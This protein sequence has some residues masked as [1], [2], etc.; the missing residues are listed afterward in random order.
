MSENS[1]IN[2]GTVAL[3]YLFSSVGQSSNENDCLEPY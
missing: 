1:T 2:I 3:A